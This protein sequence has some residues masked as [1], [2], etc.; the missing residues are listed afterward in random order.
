MQAA[1]H[2]QCGHGAPTV[3]S[4]TVLCRHGPTKGLMNTAALYRGACDCQS[5]WRGR[6]V[7][8]KN[9][10]TLSP[11]PSYRCSTH[12]TCEFRLGYFPDWPR[13]ARGFFCSVASTARSRPNNSPSILVVIWAVV[14]RFPVHGKSEWFQL[15]K[16][17]P[18]RVYKSCPYRPLDGGCKIYTHRMH[19]RHFVLKHF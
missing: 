1:K 2:P 17:V 18:T 4:S 19:G 15:P 6:F 10:G 16:A 13:I 5:K 11:H 12:S 9:C 3:T 7:M 14:M 8:R